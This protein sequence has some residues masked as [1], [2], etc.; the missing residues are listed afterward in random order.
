MDHAGDL[1]SRLAQVMPLETKVRRFLPDYIQKTYGY[2]IDRKK[3]R[4]V[5]DVVY[6]SVP[7]ALK[8]RLLSKKETLIKVLQ[9][10]GFEIRDIIGSIK[11]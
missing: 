2:E 10:Q 6:I 3:L 8:M 11:T 5:K 1:F 4:V 7:P 9:E